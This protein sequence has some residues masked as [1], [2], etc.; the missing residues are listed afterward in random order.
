MNILKQ[1]EFTI[2]VRDNVIVM[3]TVMT[4]SLYGYTCIWRKKKLKMH[5][6]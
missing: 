1:I 2:E 6:K 4:M 3:T 5:S